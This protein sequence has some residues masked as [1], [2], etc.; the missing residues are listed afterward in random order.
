M[1]VE[2]FSVGSVIHV[3]KRGA[4]GMEI[5]RD[6]SDRWR[7][8]RTL[9]LL[10]DQYQDTDWT[11]SKFQKSIFERPDHWPERRPL[12]S[13][14][15]WTLMSNHFHLLLYEAQEG[16]TSK[17]MQRLC[18]SMTTHFNEKYNEQGSIFQ[19]AYRSR[20]VDTDVYLRYVLAYILVKN[21][22]ELFPGGLS[23]AV[24]TFDI[25]WEWADTYPFS[26]F[27]T[28]AHGAESPIIDLDL[29]TELGLRT[30]EFK[31]T[32]HDMLDAYSARNLPSSVTLE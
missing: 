30:N 5:V 14:L 27:P 6:D 18:G 32:A 12:V 1:R 17:F 9:Y 28:I 3:V 4:R 10:N 31:R 22:F 16:G 8:V 2:P 26:S 23:E 15:A 11:R 29:L 19:G 24:K 13:I 20:T 7:F 25:A 21:V